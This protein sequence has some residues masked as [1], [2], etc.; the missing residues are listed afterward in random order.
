MCRV[1]ATVLHVVVGALG[2]EYLRRGQT[3]M[4]GVSAFS[5]LLLCSLSIKS[6]EGGTV[7][8]K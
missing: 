3:V 6:D 5:K 2:A 8:I 7:N 4:D 1:K